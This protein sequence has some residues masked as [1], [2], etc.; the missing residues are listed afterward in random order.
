MF[1]YEF[2]YKHAFYSEEQYQEVRSACV[3]A[4]NSK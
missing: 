4:F 1:Q 3:M 2:L